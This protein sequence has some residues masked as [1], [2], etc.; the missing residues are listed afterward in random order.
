MPVRRHA[1][2]KLL[3]AV[4][5]FGVG[6]IVF[7]VSEIFWLSLF[8]LVV[9]GLADSVSVFVRQNLVQIITPDEMRGRVS[10]VTTVFIGASNELGEFESGATAHWWGTVPAVVVGG[11]ATVT[12]AVT[13]AWLFPQLRKVDSLDPDD[14]IMRYRDRGPDRT[15]QG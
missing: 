6:V 9:M 7:G 15:P 5:T 1:G 3:F 4:G 13:F 11:A 14:L 10:A 8:A 12:V 2:L